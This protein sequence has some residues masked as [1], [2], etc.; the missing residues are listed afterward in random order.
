MDAAEEI[1]ISQSNLSKQ[2][3]KL[4]KELELTLFDRS[5]RSARLTEAG[6]AFYQE[7]LLL[8]SQYEQSLSRLSSYKEISASQFRIGT[9]PFRRA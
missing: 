4:E 7:A 5:K 9:L 3:I 8:Y 2:I 6:K 1:H